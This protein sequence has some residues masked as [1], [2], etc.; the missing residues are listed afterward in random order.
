M[1]DF[2][3]GYA[4]PAACARL[5]QISTHATMMHFAIWLPDWNSLDSVRRA[6]SELE[7][8]ALIFFALL[9]VCEALAHLSDDKKTERRFDKMGIAFF[10]I[11]VLAEIV[12]YPYGQRND[13]LSEKIIVS[14]DAKAHEA[15]SNA[16]TA[17]TKSETALGHSNEAET[18]SGEAADKAGKAQGKANAVGRQVKDLN[19]ELLA[20]NTQLDAVETK[21][22]E[23]KQS[24]DDLEICSSP[25]VIPIW[26]VGGGKFSRQRS[27]TDPL[28]GFARSVSIEYVNDAE[29]RRAATSLTI[30]LARAGWNVIEFAVWDDIEDGVSVDPYMAPTDERWT[31]DL[32]ADETEADR[33]A[34]L[35]VDFLHSFDWQAS[36]GWPLHNN[37]QIQD[38][39]ILPPKGLLIRVGLYPPVMYVSPPG[40]KFV[41]DNET[42]FAQERKQMEEEAKEGLDKRRAE[43][44]KHMAPAEIEQ[45]KAWIRQE[46]EED[47]RRRERE[48]GPCHPLNSLLPIPR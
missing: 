13:T 26:N 18:K 23:L 39:T 46:D 37:A 12:A 1:F 22:A 28:K 25:R 29:A 24:L 47:K 19:R 48:V 43:R 30:A 35:V 40:M 34:D 44:M 16:S 42:R 14:L 10:A 7:G 6:H 3:K 27:T 2:H 38:P 9:V 4:L 15:A 5:Q 41:T 33:A 36:R 32:W 8:A 45:Y 20:T 21:R 31:R 11:A 17:L